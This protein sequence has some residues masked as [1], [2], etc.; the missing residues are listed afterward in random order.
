M[1]RVV[2]LED[3]RSIGRLMESVLGDEGYEIE[4]LEDAS[5]FWPA[6]EANPPDL[7]LMDVLLGD[8]DGRTWYQEFRDRG[9]R[10]PLLLVSA[11]AGLEDIAADLGV[12]Y[13]KKP[14]DLDDLVA[15]V[16]DALRECANA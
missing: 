16:E 14:F 9:Y 10:A 8:A 12:G 4:L 11:L 6:V 5:G 7:V 13:V 2:I 3:D 15:A 1:G